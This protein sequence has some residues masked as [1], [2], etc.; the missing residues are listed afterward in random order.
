M[1]IN[2]IK[3]NNFG[4]TDHLYKELNGDFAVI[5]NNDVLL[6]L[7]WFLNQTESYVDFY[8]KIT[9]ES[10]IIIDFSHNDTTFSFRYGYEEAY[11]SVVASIKIGNYVAKGFVAEQIQEDFAKQYNSDFTFNDGKNQENK[12]KLLI[13]EL[14]QTKNDYSFRDQFGHNVLADDILSVVYEFIKSNKNVPSAVNGTLLR[15]CG[16]GSWI[17]VDNTGIQISQIPDIFQ[18]TITFEC[19]LKNNELINLI[20]KKDK[21]FDSINSPLISKIIN[22]FKDYNINRQIIFYKEVNNAE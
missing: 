8:K 16:D 6:V 17:C 14:K 4:S 13:D 9:N 15:L 21:E 11:E 12:I 2:S 18:E 7:R 1:I 10:E 19:F 3:I 22:N 20:R 5:E